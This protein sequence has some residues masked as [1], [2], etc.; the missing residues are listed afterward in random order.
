M[1]VRFYLYKRGARQ[2]KISCCR[3]DLFMRA[4]RTT[5][6]NNLNLIIMRAILIGFTILS[7]LTSL[8]T[9]IVSFNDQNI[10]TNYESIAATL[11]FGC[12]ALAMVG[13]II[14]DLTKK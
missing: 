1:I 8:T 12:G 4:I 7:G 11:F 5:A 13:T 10:M 2:Q 3:N 6:T 9:P 14:I